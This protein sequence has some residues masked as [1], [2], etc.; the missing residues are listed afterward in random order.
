[1]PLLALLAVQA[2]R[3]VAL[4]ADLPWR[5]PARRRWPEGDGIAGFAVLVAVFL[6][7]FMI[8]GHYAAIA[9]LIFALVRSSGQDGTA[10][11]A[12]IAV[13]CTAAI[14]LLFDGVLGIEMWRGL[15]LRRAAGFQDF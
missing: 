14:F 8:A 12:G 9:L 1:V 4:R 2:R 6:G 10:R 7:L 13:A 11:A 5:G 3:A 15:V